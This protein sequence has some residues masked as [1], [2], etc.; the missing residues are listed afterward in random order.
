MGR[1]RLI[2]QQM[3]D[4]GS[5][6]RE[7]L[8]KLFDDQFD[9]FCIDFQGDP[10][11]IAQARMS[12]NAFQDGPRQRRNPSGMCI[13]PFR[14]PLREQRIALRF[15]HGQTGNVNLNHALH[16]EL[17]QELLEEVFQR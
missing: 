17:V 3:R 2:P 16:R 13:D 14:I 15:M 5:Q 11:D 10:A 6:S 12:E 9:R 8:I 1:P 7:C 4:G